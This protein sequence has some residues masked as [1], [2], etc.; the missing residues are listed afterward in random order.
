ELIDA[1]GVYAWRSAFQPDPGFQRYTLPDNFQ[2]QAG[3]D[4]NELYNAGFKILGVPY[5]SGKP[6]V[7]GALNGDGVVNGADLTILLG[8]WG[9]ITDP[10]CSPADIADPPDG[11]INGAD[12][13][14]MLSN[15]T[16]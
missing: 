14:T 11:T 12:L 10:A 2:Q 7:V 6:P 16:A 5:S 4:P 3:L 15:W 8:C 1:E 9:E 13:T